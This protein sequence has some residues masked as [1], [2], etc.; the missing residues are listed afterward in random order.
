M[1]NSK[2]VNPKKTKTTKA[3]QELA[4][5]T[6]ESNNS[7]QDQTV[8]KFFN[9]PLNS[10]SRPLLLDQKSDKDLS[11]PPITELKTIGSEE[12]TLPAQPQ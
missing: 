6:T 4:I 1:Y 5:L 12:K 8:L 7:R 3:S 2:S 11:K 9:T 10:D